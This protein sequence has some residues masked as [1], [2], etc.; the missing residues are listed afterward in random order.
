MANFAIN[1]VKKIIII[2]PHRIGS[3][4]LYSELDRMLGYKEKQIIPNIPST[5][6]DSIMEAC[7]LKEYIVQQAELIYA[8]DI[9]W[10]NNLDK[11][12]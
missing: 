9:E 12:G 1:Y 6:W 8:P 3:S 7:N 11:I 2:C 10:Y 5:Q 4:R